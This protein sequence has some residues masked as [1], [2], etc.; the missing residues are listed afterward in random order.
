MAICKFLVVKIC[1]SLF[2][3]KLVDQL[4]FA[5]FQE[6]ISCELLDISGEHMSV[7][8][9]AKINRQVAFVRGN[10]FSHDQSF[11]LERSE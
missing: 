7:R 1:E 9:E 3:A 4:F 10:N 11:P 5:R 2:F 6:A 8:C